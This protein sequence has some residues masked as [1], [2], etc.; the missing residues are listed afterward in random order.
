ME[1]CIEKGADP[2]KVRAV[3]RFRTSDIDS[4]NMIMAIE[5]LKGNPDND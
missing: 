2:L 3:F 4:L 5:N 1:R